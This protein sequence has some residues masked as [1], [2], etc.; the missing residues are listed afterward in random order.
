M[1]RVDEAESALR[2]AIVLGQGMD[3]PA[4]EMA[5][6]YH[7]LGESLWWQNRTDEQ[8][9]VGQEGA[10]LLG[11]DDESLEAV[12][13]NEVMASG[14]FSRGEPENCRKCTV[15]TAR[16]I[17]RLPYVE[18]LRSAY[19]HIAVVK[20]YVDKDPAKAL[21]WLRALEQRAEPQDDRRALGEV[22]DWSGR[23]LAATGDL[24]GAIARHHLAY[25]LLSQTGD[26]SLKGWCLTTMGRAFLLSGDLQNAHECATAGLSVAKTAGH[27]LTMGQ[28]YWCAGQV[29]LAQNAWGEALDALQNAIQPSEEKMDFRWGEG[30]VLGHAHLAQG[31]REQA[32]ERFQ[33]VAA[34][35]A[36]ETSSRHTFELASALSGL[37]DAY[38]DAGGFYGFC[39]RLQTAY[40]ETRDS[41]FVQWYLE[42]IDVDTSRRSTLFLEDFAELAPGW[43]W[44][45]PL[46]DCSYTLRDGLELHAANGRHLWRINRSAP[47]LLRQASGDFAV[48]TACGPVSDRPA[49]GGLLLWKDEQHYV[50]LSWG[51]P[52][53]QGLLFAGCVDNVDLVIGRGRL[54]H[55]RLQHV[56]L[57]LERV[58]ATVNATCSVD[59]A[60]WSTVGSVQFPIQDPVQV[61]IH[62][63]GAID[64]AANPGAYPEGTAIRF[65]SFQVW[66]V[67]DRSKDR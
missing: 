64:R 8:I 2:E 15:H 34:L 24:R 41:P 53:P 17:D 39:R 52:G 43:R 11:D 23:I 16:F 6:L 55:E 30:Y 35:A 60:S 46:R 40:P 67:R 61:G 3:L 66:Q 51:M 57:C 59:G 48:Q 26:A 9:R 36:S 45:D 38:G 13:M 21:A 18:E 25:D 47:R 42:P 1:G 50:H 28:A 14:Y 29:L 5:R 12:L 27:R 33:E 62:A 4:R 19:L 56:H 10:A 58:G 37:Q 54:P 65:E 32:I 7:W 63:I 22:H 49:I 44:E 20:T 31:N